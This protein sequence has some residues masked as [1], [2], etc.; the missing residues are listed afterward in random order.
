ME[1]YGDPKSPELRHVLANCPKADRSASMTS[2]RW[3]TARIADGA[4]SRPLAVL[5]RRVTQRRRFRTETMLICDVTTPYVCP[6]CQGLRPRLCHDSS[7]R[8]LL[9]SSLPP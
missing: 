1:K 5:T 6:S 7:R 3:C 9:L 2:A 4:L 8:P